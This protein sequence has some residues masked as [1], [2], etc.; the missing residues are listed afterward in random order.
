VQ[1]RRNAHA[2]NSD[3]ALVESPT[4][5]H[6]KLL[7]LTPRQRVVLVR[8]A[9]GETNSVIAQALF[10]SPGTV[11]KHLEHIYEKL[12]VRNRTE[13]AAAYNRRMSAATEY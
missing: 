6:G 3:P 8:A 11:S 10:V 4:E 1:L 12:E 7:R 2:R 5:N 13:A 9:T